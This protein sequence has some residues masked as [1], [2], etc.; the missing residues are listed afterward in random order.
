MADSKTPEDPPPDYDKAAAE[1]GSA[2]APA[3]APR[4]GGGPRRPLP[5]NIPILKHLNSK[6]V[7]LASA[8][9]RRK[10]LLQ[11]VCSSSPPL[12]FSRPVS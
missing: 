8:S 10:M 12:S 4:P 3:A 6:R 1:H 5:L 2:P 11:Q 7:I 9:P